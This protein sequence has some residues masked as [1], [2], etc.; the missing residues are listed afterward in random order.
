MPDRHPLIFIRHGETDWNRAARFQGQHDVPLNALGRR[1]AERNGRAVAGILASGAWDFVASPLSRTVETMRIAL[2]AAGRADESFST[3]PR[4]K[5]ASYGDWEGLTLAEIN[6]LDAGVHERR[7]LD[8]WGFVPPSGESYAD[9]SERV[10]EWLATLG[11][12][13]L[14][15]AHAGI[16]RGLLFRLAGLPADEAPHFTV[17]HDRVILFTRQRVLTI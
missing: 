2:A 17:P 5:E 6:A 8:K 12:P 3:D 10:A 15:V 4:L 9:V 13:T 7:A 11:G 1:Q 16:M 14:V